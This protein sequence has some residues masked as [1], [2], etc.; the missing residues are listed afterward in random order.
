MGVVRHDLSSEIACPGC[1][2]PVRTLFQHYDG[3]KA[4]PA[5]CSTCLD[6]P[7]AP[8]M[9]RQREAPKSHKSK[10]RKRKCV[11]DTIQSDLLS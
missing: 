7:G 5:V 3:T 6:V 9:G 11:I 10:P 2:D 1:G 4:H 8:K